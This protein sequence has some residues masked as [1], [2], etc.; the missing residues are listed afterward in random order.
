MTYLSETDPI[1]ARKILL[2]QNKRA[3]HKNSSSQWA[4][5]MARPSREP[6]GVSEAIKLKRLA[7]QLTSKGMKPTTAICVSMAAISRTYTCIF[8]GQRSDTPRF[9]G[10]YQC[11]M[12]GENPTWRLTMVRHGS[13]L[14]PTSSHSS[15]LYQAY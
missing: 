7:Y 10:L 6:T 14:V 13:I 2:H 9:K 8:R 12:Y 1:L 3:A 4:H 11:R 5:G 15:G